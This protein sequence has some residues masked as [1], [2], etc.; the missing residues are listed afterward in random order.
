MD[1]NIP[2][3]L[4]QLNIIIPMIQNN[5]INYDDLQTFINEAKKMLNVTN[6]SIHQILNDPH[7]GLDILTTAFDPLELY[8]N[9]V[10]L[11][12]LSLVSKHLHKF[13]ET[14]YGKNKLEIFILEHYFEYCDNDIDVS[15]K[16]DKSILPCHIKYDDDYVTMPI[17]IKLF[18]LKKLRN[19]LGP[20]T[21]FEKYN[22]IF[23]KDDVAYV[24]SNR[25]KCNPDHCVFCYKQ[26]PKQYYCQ[27]CRKDHDVDNLQSHNLNINSYIQNNNLKNDHIDIK[28]E[29]YMYNCR[30]ICRDTW[31]NIG[32]TKH[33]IQFKE[34][35]CKVILYINP[36]IQFIIKKLNI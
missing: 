24:N 35:M 22:V 18:A 2:F 28:Y 11:G 7:Y 34:C 26:I 23:F 30:C 20:E 17:N 3:T 6:T 27:N 25:I 29:Q 9:S 4:Q 14:K 5:K 15:I 36:E 8:L 32:N 21:Y 31:H 10:D 13:I 33:K 19:I 16:I 1:I 12:S